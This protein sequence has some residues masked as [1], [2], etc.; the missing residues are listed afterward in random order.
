MGS[1]YR[2]GKVWWIKYYRNGK[3]YRESS[4][5][6]KKMVAKKLLDRREGE[7]ASGKVPAILFEKVTFDELADEFITDYR[8]NNKK[9][10]DRAELSVS[11]LRQEFEGINV[12]DITTPRITKYVDDRMKWLCKAC[13]NKFH[14]NGEKHCPK[15]GSEVLKK[16]A[17]NAT[18]NRELSA[19]KR[20]LN[21]GARQT[22]PKVDRIPH[23]PLLKE[24]NTRK[25]FFEHEEFIA[26]KNALPSHLKTFAAFGYRIGW[27]HGEIAKLKWSQVN[28][29]QGIVRLEAGETKN[30]EG[31]TVYLDG[32][33]KGMFN[34]LWE[35]RKLSSKLLPWVF[36]NETGT[37]RVKRFDKA[38][39]TACKKAKIGVRLFHD[40]R[41]TAVRNMV[42]AGVPERVA[43]MVSGHKTRSVFD[44]YNIVNDSD[45]RLAAQR[46]QEYLDSQTGTIS[47]T[48]HGFKPKTAK[49]EST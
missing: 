43:M 48:I 15:C 5:T 41:R 29:K 34:E 22:P 44:R 6:T 13:G 24:N 8:I 9:S 49:S 2:R 37:D 31:R 42:R 17:K 23:I 12:P 35:A 25:G 46:H 10:I 18:I 14:F 47:G 26:V 16:G 32:E 30:D 19:L 7:I 28:L 36:L 11:H 4:K 45:L 38:W 33:L 39:K 20:L 27:R 40:L 3:S 21:L 1:L